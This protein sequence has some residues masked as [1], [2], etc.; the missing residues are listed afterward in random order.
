MTY[1]LDFMGFFLS[2]TSHNIVYTLY[3]FSVF[4]ER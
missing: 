4:A 3:Y 1:V 2:F